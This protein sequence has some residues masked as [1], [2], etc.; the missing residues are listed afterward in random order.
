[1]TAAITEMAVAV[2]AARAAAS[3]LPT[4]TPLA[5]GTPSQQADA[6]PG[7]GQA[8]FAGFTGA[9]RGQIAV[10]LAQELID[11]LADTPMAGIELSQAVRPALEAAAAA[12]GPVTVD[13]GELL[14]APDA[15]AAIVAAGGALVPLTSAAGTAAAV[16]LVVTA[17]G[18]APA[19]GAGGAA[20]LG[21]L[22]EVEL[23]VT[24][25]LG[26]TRMTV[27]ELLA[28]T[29]GAVIE[30]DGAAGGPVDL[31]VNGRVIARGEVV[32]IDESFGI[33]IIEIVAGGR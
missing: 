9:A 23:E 2:D 17:T 21:L 28:L 24:A 26:R 29:P 30:L 18:P 16:A 1:V 27:R 20:D 12:L 8:I 33:R 5:V 10:V 25:E 19:A 6:A 14:P 7:T 22:H 15:V 31:L 4:T 13:P 32:V 11:A 3:L